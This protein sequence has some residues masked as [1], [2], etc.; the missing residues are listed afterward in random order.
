MA[1][2]DRRPVLQLPF[3]AGI[4]GAGAALVAVLVAQAIALWLLPATILALLFPGQA[5]AVG[6]ALAIGAI[7]AITGGLIGVAVGYIHQRRLLRL[8]AVADAWLRG[9]LSL[10]TDE[11]ARD[12]LGALAHRLNL[13]VEHLEEDEQ[14]LDRLRESNVR[15]TD[16][17]RALVVVEERNRL[18]R[19]LHDSVKQHLF[20]L[21]MTASAIR[22]HLDHLQQS[23]H[24]PSA[25]LSE[26][27]HE[28]ETEAQAA[29]RETTRLIED[30]RPASLHERGL[31]AA[32]NDYTLLFGAR[33]H[34]LAYL[35]VQCNDRALPPP[36]TEALYRV[37]QEA[38]HNVARHA[39]ATR[40]NVQVRCIGDRVV[41]TVEDNGIGFDTRRTR[42]GLGISSMQERL[43][44]IGGR[45]QVE[46]EPNLGTTVRAEVEIGAGVAGGIQGTSIDPSTVRSRPEAWAWLGQK[47]MIPVGQ[48][49]PWPPADVAR[50]LRAPAIG[51]GSLTLRSDRR[52]L[53]LLRGHMLWSESQRAPL[54]RF[55]S[56]R[57]GMGWDLGGVDWLLREIR[58]LKGRAVVERNAQPLAAMQHAGD[59]TTP[60]HTEIIY[61]DHA[62]RLM[63]NPEVPS[64]FRLADE[65]DVTVLTMEEDSLWLHRTLPLPLI[66]AVAARIID[67]RS[68]QPVRRASGARHPE[69]AGD[70][71]Q[72]LLTSLRQEL[73]TLTRE[74]TEGLP[75]DIR[76]RV[77]ALAHTLLTILPHID[78]LGGS[79]HDAYVV[80]QIVRDYLP[81]ALSE[82]R[83]LPASYALDEP[84]QEGKTARDHLLEQLEL[85]QQVVDAV[86]ARLPQEHVQHLLSHGRFLAGKFAAGRGSGSDD[87]GSSVETS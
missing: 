69:P 32:L 54:L 6:E 20:S 83:A 37:A 13:L 18:A 24:E 28:I 84:I 67:E 9:D 70:A 62:Y 63:E 46:S 76:S 22:T 77:E 73:R 78:N 17:V 30:L 87:E 5:L 34:L 33:Q 79:S 56:E 2:E 45:L 19:E 4:I 55:S 47:L 50:H 21:A 68:L 85:L 75:P 36:V 65:T 39:H 72:T 43:M 61:D 60:P 82:Y 12:E 41:L 26:M 3:R 64:G 42:K 1:R 57:A 25:E 35:D 14:D 10:R 86:A 51:P 74:Q 66:A 52:L 16:Q 38:L 44:A 80:R 58:G 11:Q 29:Q 31:A 8:N 53:G 48:T 15:L 59:G 81:T 7:A 27:I 49:W 40:V 71:D 23:G